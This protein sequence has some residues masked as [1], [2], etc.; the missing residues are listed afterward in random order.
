MTDRVVNLI[1]T[2]FKDNAQ[3][4]R[5]YNSK[6]KEVDLH[7]DDLVRPGVYVHHKYGKA[8]K[9]GRHFDNVRKRAL[10][11]IQDDTG[12]EM[13]ALK[14]DDAAELLL[15]TVDKDKYYWAATLEIFLEIN[16]K[17][18]ISSKRIG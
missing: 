1:N 12:H 9:V 11:H 13:A 7:N 4:F 6:L 18:K 14:N 15:I 2:E 10:E 3:L 5:Y 17:P 8:I 16:L